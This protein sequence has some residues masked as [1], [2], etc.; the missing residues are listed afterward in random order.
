LADDIYKCIESAC[1][2]T[3]KGRHHLSEFEFIITSLKKVAGFSSVGELGIEFQYSFAV[4]NQQEKKRKGLS[5]YRG[6]GRQYTAK[7]CFG[8]YE[9]LTP[10]LESIYMRNFHTGATHLHITAIYKPPPNLA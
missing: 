4:V 5:M 2:Q 9:H 6:R 10:S 3:T 7:M 8:N 1:C